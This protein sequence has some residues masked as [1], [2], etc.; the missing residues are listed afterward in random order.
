MYF[1]LFLHNWNSPIHKKWFIKTGTDKLARYSLSR[2][3]AEARR[4]SHRCPGDAPRPS[5]KLQQE[6]QLV[7]ALPKASTHSAGVFHTQG[8]GVIKCRPF[9]PLHLCHRT[10]D[11]ENSNSTPISSEMSLITQWLTI[12]TGLEMLASRKRNFNKSRIRSKV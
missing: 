11:L 5:T 2:C 6:R 3:R 9:L 8:Y 7:V 12:W 1:N 4:L 10:H